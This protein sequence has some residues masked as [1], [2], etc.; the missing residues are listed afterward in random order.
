LLLFL[1]TCPKNNND[2]DNNKILHS[3]MSFFEFY[4]LEVPM[5]VPSPDLL[6]EWHMTYRA[7]NE[8]TWNSVFGILASQS[9]LSKHPLS[10]S[11]MNHDP[12]NDMSRDAVREWL[13]L[14]DFY[15]VPHVTQFDSW[16][17]LMQ[18]LVTCDLNAIS[19]RMR[20]YNVESA[21]TIKNNWKEVLARV[22]KGKR[23]KRSAFR[24]KGV[25]S[26]GHDHGHGNGDG[27]GATVRMEGEAEAGC[28]SRGV[29]V[30]LDLDIALLKSYPAAVPLQGCLNT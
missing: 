27:D 23:E 19:K 15:Q 16:D 3:F 7:V 4:R 22:R 5:F 14:A 8:R 10:T 24:D 21:E 12:N 25:D 1:L 26:H 20:S 29:T 13:G 18:L 17:H 2:N 11:N 30:P 28:H 6:T 9:V